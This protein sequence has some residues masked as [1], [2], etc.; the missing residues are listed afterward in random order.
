M[1]YSEFIADKK[2]SVISSGFLVDEKTL[3]SNMFDFQKHIVKKA[4]KKGRR[5]VDMQYSLIVD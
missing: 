1:E 5:R 3:N 2:K 4:L